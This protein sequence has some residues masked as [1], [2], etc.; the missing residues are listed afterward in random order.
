MNL[1][2]AYNPKGADGKIYDC[3]TAPQRISALGRNDC[4]I[5]CL[6]KFCFRMGHIL[7]QRSV[8]LGHSSFL[9]AFYPPAT[10]LILFSL[11]F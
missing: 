5:R 2:T 1:R 10:L 4:H 7:R 8:G 11:Q 3:F 6:D 9:E